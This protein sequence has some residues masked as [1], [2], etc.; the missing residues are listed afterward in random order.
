MN[1]CHGK[2]WTLCE[3]VVSFALSFFLNSHLNFYFIRLNKIDDKCWTILNGRGC[4]QSLFVGFLDSILII[5]DSNT[6]FNSLAIRLRS[7]DLKHLIPGN[8]VP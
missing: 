4:F 2:V 6:C 7:E 8:G 5:H 1:V 3:V